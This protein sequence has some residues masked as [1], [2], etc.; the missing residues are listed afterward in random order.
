MEKKKYKILLIDDDELLAD[1]Y[2]IKFSESEFE[3]KVAFNGADALEKIRKGFNPDVILLDIL[4]PVMDGFELLRRIKQN[5]LLKNSKKIILSNLGQEE[6]IKKGLS[7]G[8]DDYIIKASFI[9]SQIIKKIKE[10][11]NKKI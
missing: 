5:N 11:I 6:E 3:T 9:P 2:S 7:L 4:M 1:M 10:I 8:A